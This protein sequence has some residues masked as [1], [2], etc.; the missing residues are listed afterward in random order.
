M[1]DAHPD[2]QAERQLSLEEFQGKMLMVC[3]TPEDFRVNV[4]D[5]VD[6]QDNHFAQIVK[7]HYE[8]LKRYHKAK[9]CE[10]ASVFRLEESVSSSECRT[11]KLRVV[12]WVVN[13]ILMRPITE[14]QQVSTTDTQE[15]DCEVRSCLDDI[16]KKV[17]DD[18]EDEKLAQWADSL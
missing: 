5:T 12:Q 17:I 14:N 1:Y 8:Y 16:T 13:D 18:V 15:V 7:L 6:E 11:A 3:K 4:T 9:I 2:W 10:F